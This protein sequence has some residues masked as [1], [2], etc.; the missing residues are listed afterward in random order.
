MHLSTMSADRAARSVR[1][2]RLLTVI[3][4]GV[5]AGGQVRGT[6]S[7]A[8]R[9]GGWLQVGG[10]WR[11]ARDGGLGGWPQRP[12]EL[13]HPRGRRRRGGAETYAR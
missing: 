4:Q 10:G 11:H 13:R 12:G 6:G 8:V 9:G 1:S 3:L 5:A 7:G 2:L